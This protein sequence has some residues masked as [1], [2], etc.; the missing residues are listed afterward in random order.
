MAQKDYVLDEEEL[1]IQQEMDAYV[2][3]NKGKLGQ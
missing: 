3:A 1:Q 2:E